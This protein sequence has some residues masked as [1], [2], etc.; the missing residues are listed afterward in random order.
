MA[1]MFY[2]LA[3][4]AEKLGATEDAVKNMATQGKLQQ[5]RDRDKLMFKRDQVDALSAAKADDDEVTGIS[6]GAI[7]LDETGLSIVARGALAGG[8]AHNQQS[9]TSQE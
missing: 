6:S 7:P 5:F 3:E 8:D 4:T 2:T 1:K 9:K